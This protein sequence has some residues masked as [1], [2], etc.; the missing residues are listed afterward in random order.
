MFCHLDH[1]AASAYSL[2][3]E[4]HVVAVSHGQLHN[5]ACSNCLHWLGNQS[6]AAI[7]LLSCLSCDNRKG[8]DT[9]S[10]QRDSVQPCL[11]SA[12]K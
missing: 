8:Q 6:I 3:C 1:T 9:L 11:S 4:L 2:V 7:M 10:L 12:P 5:V